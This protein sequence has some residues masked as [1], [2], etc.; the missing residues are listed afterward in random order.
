MYFSRFLKVSSEKKNLIHNIFHLSFFQALNYLLPLLLIPYLVRVIG[1]EHFGLLAFSTATVMYFNIISDYGFNLSAVRE[2]SI[3]R[4]NKKKIEE[5]YSAVMSIKF[6]LVLISFILLSFVIFSL[7]KFSND[8]KIYVL[9]YGI[10]IG[11]SLFPLFLFQGLQK[12]K[13]VTYLNALP[14][15]FFILLIFI[16]VKQKEDYWIV[17]LFNSLGYIFSGFFAL[18]YVKHKLQIRFKNQSRQIL[19]KHL[20]EGWH[21]FFSSISI[22]LYTISS[23]FILGLLSNNTFV[24]YFSAAEK[25]IQAIKGL[26]VPISQAIY[27]HLSK[28]LHHNKTQGLNFIKEFTL[29]SGSVTFLFCCFIFIMSEDIVKFILGQQY[30]ASIPLLKIMSFLPLLALLSNIFGIQIMLNLGFKKIF[31]LILSLAAIFSIILSLLLVPKL[32]ATGTAINILIIEIFVTFAM[33]IFLCIKVFH[34][35]NKRI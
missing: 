6:I 10:V 21:V 15:L 25:I 1:P 4:K 29:Y 3:Q 18:Y 26:Y 7:D 28:M 23:V 14:K 22:S 13:D 30:L 5:I 31:S 34:N 12:L 19:K 9:T 20:I 33:G 32:N 16:C 27:P 2:I 24:G 17:P 8:W 35:E 11:Q